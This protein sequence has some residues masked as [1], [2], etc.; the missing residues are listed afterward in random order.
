MRRVASVP[1]SLALVG[2][3][4]AELTCQPCSAA[5][6]QEI[7]DVHLTRSGRQYQLRTLRRY[8][9][10][11]VDRNVVIDGFPGCLAGRPYIVTAYAD[12]FSRGDDFLRFDTARDLNVYIA[13]DRR[14]DGSRPKWLTSFEPASGLL[15][16]SSEPPAERSVQFDV[17]VKSFQSGTVVLGGNLAPS[18]RRNFAMYIVILAERDSDSCED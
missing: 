4:V 9:Y 12:K 13:Y 1:T 7:V 17:L 5:S 8:S 15:S 14:W 6:Q 18:E 11:Y 10:A 16:T 2:L 3:V